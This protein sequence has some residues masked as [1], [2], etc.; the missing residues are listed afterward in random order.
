MDDLITSE[1]P[2]DVCFGCGQRNDRGL[3]MA[4]RKTSSSSME[5]VYVV[6][7]HYCGPAGIVHGGIQAALLDEVLGMS[8]HAGEADRRFHIVTAEFNLRYRRPVPTNTPLVISGR[9]VR[10]A[11]PDYFVE[12]EITDEAGEVLTRAEARWKRLG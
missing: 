5:A 3:R 9:V 8:I 11:D 10:A 1:G 4:F 12:G 6:P 2:E 7:D